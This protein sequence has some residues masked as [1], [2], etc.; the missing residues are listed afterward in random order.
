[1]SDTINLLPADEGGMPLDDLF[2]WILEQKKAGFTRLDL[3]KTI[4]VTGGFSEL[5]L[6]AREES[7]FDDQ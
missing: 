6:T 7:Q 2:D 1:M 5:E 3:Y 4:D